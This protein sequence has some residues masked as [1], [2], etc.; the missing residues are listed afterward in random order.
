MA[1]ATLGY[2]LRVKVPSLSNAFSNHFI[3]KFATLRFFTV[4]IPCS[5][6]FAISTY[7]ID[8]LGTMF[9][10]S[11]DILLDIT[12]LI[13]EFC[14]VELIFILCKMVYRIDKRT[15]GDPRHCVRSQE[16]EDSEIGNPATVENVDSE[17]GRN[18]RKRT[19]MLAGPHTNKN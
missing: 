17:A 18:K 16:N 8:T 4:S 2:S 13:E 9:C 15:E 14:S 11:F 1:G 6:F 12:I 7:Y 10:A 19:Q 3:C 5:H